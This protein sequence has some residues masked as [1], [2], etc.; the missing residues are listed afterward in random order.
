MQVYLCVSSSPSPAFG[1]AALD[2][3]VRAA[4]ARALPQESGPWRAEIWRAPGGTSA[5]YAWSNQP[6]RVRALPALLY[7]QRERA[8]GLAGYLA[9]EGDWQALI[10]AADPGAVADELG[11]VFGVFRA[12]PHGFT[13]VTTLVRVEPVYHAAAGEVQLAGNRALLVHL[14]HRALAADG[15]PDVRYDLAAIAA[16]VRHGFFMGE[17]TPFE[18]VR[19]LAAHSTLAVREAR[20]DIVTRRLPARRPASARAR[21]GQVRRLARSLA[22]AVQPLV[23]E[24]DLLLSLTGGRDSRMIAAALHAGG[25]RF[26]AF[27]KGFDDDPDVI[28]AA[29]IARTLGVAHSSRAPALSQDGTAVV[30]EDPLVR[31]QRTIRCVE[32]MLSTLYN[33]GP[34]GAF[35]TA[36]HLTG[37]GGEQLRGGY[38]AGLNDLAPK[39][40]TR[41]VKS[42]FTRYDRLQTEWGRQ[43]A[44]LDR[45]P[46]D[47]IA[48]RD[49]LD[50]LDRLY[51]YDRSGRWAAA[52]RA[53][54]ALTGVMLYPLFDNLV[55]RHAMAM[56]PHWRWT[57]EPIHQV[58][59]RLAPPLRDLPM[60]KKRWR[61][62]PAEPPRVV[63]RRS[64][65]AQTPVPP[66]RTVLGGYDWRVHPDEGLAARLREQ[67]L[68]GPAA[69]FEIV[70][71]AAVE[72]VLAVAP[73][74]EAHF[75]WQIYT[76]SVLL[77]GSWQ[78]VPAARPNVEVSVI[79]A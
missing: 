36:A 11:G 50:A 46:W 77:S 54:A 18:G 28:V 66:G 47:R 8:L 26:A 78:T 22:Q 29:R 42:T 1:A 40:V 31:T 24:P 43:R 69:R 64:W 70:D 23:G 6:P 7:R 75:A 5:L 32:G 48:R 25:V 51:L 71:R 74:R 12:E 45:A 37:A 72:E 13:A 44:R 9:N 60:A 65:L 62:A 15:P 39:V 57:E 34:R 3:I 68:D 27:T 73:L 56:D 35:R 30:I 16:L 38:L 4:A 52:T 53:A 41:R 61:F 58:I 49:P 21:R 10:T 33:I 59:A 14:V 63:G 55:T 79:G 76:A 19:A 17:G 20:A 67:I 2:R